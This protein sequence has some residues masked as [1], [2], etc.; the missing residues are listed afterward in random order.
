MAARTHCRLP[1]LR[2]DDAMIVIG[3]DGIEREES[4]DYLLQDGETVQFIRVPMFAMDAVQR[5]VANAWP[6]G[7]TDASDARWNAYLKFKQEVSE[8][9]RQPASTD[10]Q[11]EAL[12]PASSSDPRTDAY[13]EYCASLANRWQA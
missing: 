4:D 12:K 11:A 5:E 7:L 9:W 6:P 13:A 10:N 8:R 3:R 1:T 2:R